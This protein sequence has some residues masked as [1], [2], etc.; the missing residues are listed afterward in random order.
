VSHQSILPAPISCGTGTFRLA[1]NETRSITA[2]P[3]YAI[4]ASHVEQR[5]SRS[6]S[7][8]LPAPS[9]GW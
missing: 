3:S 4:K 7:S 9:V 6:S 1:A 8:I 2:D 5:S